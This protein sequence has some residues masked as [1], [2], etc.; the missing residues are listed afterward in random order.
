MSAGL[1]VL[2][3][4]QPFLRLRVD[5]KQRVVR[6][7]RGVEVR[8]GTR[9]SGGRRHILGYQEDMVR[10]AR[11]YDIFKWMPVYLGKSGAYL[12]PHELDVQRTQK[13]EED[14]V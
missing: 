12:I 4:R 8:G 1:E 14:N 11:L 13:A 3:R 7:R 2:A 9:A 10:E 5:S 6:I